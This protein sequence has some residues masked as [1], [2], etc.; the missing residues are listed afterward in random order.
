M[1]GQLRAATIED[2][3]LLFEWANDPLVRKNSFSSEQIPYEEHR[4]WYA[5]LLERKDRKQY[6]YEYENEPIGQIRLS[7]DGDTA[8]ISYSICASKRGMGHGKNM[9]QLL[10]NQVIIDLPDVKKLLGKV[11]MDNVAS[12]KAF[13][14]VGYQENY[15]TFE[16]EVGALQVNDIH[17]NSGWYSI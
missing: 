13:L 2:M 9:L 11:K 10:S 8:V 7:I 15:K 4:E 17:I 14:E 6:I 5:K 16:M 3:D 12:Q 1:N